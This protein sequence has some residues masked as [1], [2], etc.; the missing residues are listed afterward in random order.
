[1]CSGNICRSPMGEIVLR[2]VVDS[3]VASTRV[4]SA[5]LSALSGGK[6]HGL[7][8]EVLAERGYVSAGFESRYLRPDMLEESDLVLTMTE[9]HRSACQQM[10]PAR[11]RR[12]F[13]LVEFTALVSELGDVGLD[14]VMGSRGRIDANSADL[15]IA[16]PL[17]QPKEVFERVFAEIEPR[18]AVVAAW[19]AGDVKGHLRSISARELSGQ[20]ADV[21]TGDGRSASEANRPSASGDGAPGAVND[22]APPM[23]DGTGSEGDDGGG[24]HRQTRKMVLVGVGVVALLIA[25][26]LGWLA[27]SAFHVRDSLERAKTDAQR[28]RTLILDGN[29]AGAK[30]AAES[31]AD[32]ARS[33]SDSA[34]GLVWSAAAAIPWLGDPLK[35]VREMSEAVDDY[36]SHVLVPSADLAGVLDP[37]Q[38][39]KGDTISTEPLRAAQPRLVAMS[40]KS[41]AITRRVAGIDP[42]WLGTVADARHQ[43]VDVIDSA[44]ATVQGTSVAANLVP[45]MLG[46]DGPRNYFLALQTPSEARA[47]GGLL[48]GFGILNA[49][50]G[51]ATTPELGRNSDLVNPPQAQLAL[52]ADFD[53]LY[54]WTKAYTDN[55]NNNISPNFPDA[56]RIWIAN[57]K[58]QSGQQLDGA[59]ALDPIAL[60]YV[61]K[62]TGPVTLPDG[63]KITT[64][65]VVPITLSTSY[66]R[67]ANDNNARKAYLQSISKAVI[68]QLSHA[69]G[70]TG[71]LLEAL[72][73]GVHERRIMVYSTHPDE[74]KILGTTNLGHQLPDSS[75]PYMNVTLG[76]VAGNKIDYYL[77]RNIS[78]ISGPCTGQTRK[79]TGSITLTNTLKDLSLP[80]YVI[81]SMG[82]L[83]A[84]LPRGTNFSNVQFTLTRGATIDSI[85]VN[86]AS[87]LY[88]TGELDGHTVVYTQVRVPAGESVTVDVTFTEPTSAHGNAQVPVQPLVDNPTPTV[89]VPECGPGG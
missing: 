33:A 50:N 10:L 62:V 51:H 21:G 6:M 88:S 46:A 26:A 89:K 49:T 74:E 40:V 85:S 1:M 47:T 79:S 70:D 35:S 72:G 65:N 52:G 48:G 64:D 18:V 81:G 14:E 38:L 29:S 68:T 55:R 60:S 39:R 71:A 78:Y 20:T 23:N 17:G 66:E 34:N 11:W 3:S 19:L 83:R 27:Y 15:D 54:G 57:W 56:A 43:L 53:D 25:I 30:A 4:A 36:A 41:E 76:N 24:Q 45:S 58:A 22:G 7:S 44:N 28:A 77:R 9:R 2:S 16:D 31:A 61:L 5:G 82:A 80:D 73:R 84:Q 63:E 75:A 32:E 42:S 13:T 67:F 69:S 59:I 86:G 12:V 8:A 87:T 37:S